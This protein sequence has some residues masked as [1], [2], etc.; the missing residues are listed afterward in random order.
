MPRTAFIAC[1]RRLATTFGVG[2]TCFSFCGHGAP[3]LCLRGGQLSRTDDRGA[4]TTKEKSEGEP[5]PVPTTNGP[6]LTFLVVAEFG[7][8]ATALCRRVR[9]LARSH[10][11]TQR[12]G[13]KA[14]CQMVR[15]TQLFH[16]HWRPAARGVFFQVRRNPRL[17]GLPVYPPL[18][19]RCLLAPCP[20]ARRPST[21]MTVGVFYDGNYFNHGQHVL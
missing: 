14:D 20:S 2:A 8:V 21:L 11:A 1:P 19:C 9:R 17:R 13:Y 12:C 3:S 10:T 5:V 6:Q 7:L 15:T 4:V 18:F 16:P